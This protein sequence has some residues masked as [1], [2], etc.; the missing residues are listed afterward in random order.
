MKD[1]R[2]NEKPIKPKSKKVEFITPENRLAEVISTKSGMTL[3]EMEDEVEKRIKLIRDKY[4]E[5]VRT[6]VA[7]MNAEREKDAPF[8]SILE[9]IYVSAHDLKGQSGTLGFNLVGDVASCLCDA[10]TGAPKKLQA[11]PDILKLHINA[12]IWALEN[13][14]NDAVEKQ[15]TALLKSLQESVRKQR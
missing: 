8:T 9:A 7:Q 10:I 15:K 3:Q 6:I 13:E 11:E 1:D 14:H 12:I 2:E 4:P 5:K